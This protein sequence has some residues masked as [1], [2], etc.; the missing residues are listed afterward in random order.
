MNLRATIFSQRP[1]QKIADIK[2]AM[3]KI[4]QPV[5]SKKEIVL[6]T[7]SNVILQKF[8]T[9]TKNDIRKSRNYIRMWYDEVCW[10]GRIKI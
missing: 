8:N 2:S 7:I 5:V 3:T 4:L 6:L 1:F 10:N 9:I